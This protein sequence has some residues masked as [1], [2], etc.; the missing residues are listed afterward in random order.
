LGQFL[1]GQK[2]V[3]TAL[4]DDEFEID[5][6]VG[7][8]DACDQFRTLACFS[9]WLLEKFEPRG[10]IGEEVADFDFRAAG[11]A[12]LSWR[13]ILRAYLQGSPIT[14]LRAEAI[15]KRETDAML[16]RAS[17]RKP[18]LLISCKSWRLCSLL[19]AWRVRASSS[20][21]SEMPDPLSLTLMLD[22]PP[23]LIWIR[24]R[25]AP[26]S[27]AVLDKLFQ[28]AGRA[29]DH[30]SRRDLVL[31]FGRQEADLLLWFHDFSGPQIPIERG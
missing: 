8:C 6:K 3:Q 30:L 10:D 22:C 12:V 29:L 19:V 2:T 9:G 11:M 13:R 7:E 28:N 20:W 27:S 31:Q 23:S 15:R 18:K 5:M 1:P 24:S 25:V 26:A 21:S 4:A 16:G 14:I 17:P